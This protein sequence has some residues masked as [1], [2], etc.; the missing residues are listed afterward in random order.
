TSGESYT[1]TAFSTDAAT[2]VS[3][4]ATATFS[5]DSTIPTVAITYPVNASFYNTASWTGSITG[6]AADTL[7]GAVAS[8]SVRIQRSSDGFYWNGAS[9]VSG[10]QTLA[11]T[12]TTAW[13]YGLA[14]SALNDG[15]TYTVTAFSTD[16][17]GNNSTN[18]TVAFVYD[19]TLPT[20][21]I[22]F[23]VDGV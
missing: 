19:T 18:A 4:N 16:N 13:S 22:A 8:A 15:V 12:G 2:N 9:W 14:A 11:A 1:V 23:P 17:A 20:A 7:P 5:Y 6:T 3:T 21:T 10:V